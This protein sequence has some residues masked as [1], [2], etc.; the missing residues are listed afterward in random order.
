SQ[1]GASGPAVARV[2]V[3]LDFHCQPRM[4]ARTA[5]LSTIISIP[6]RKASRQQRSLKPCS[7]AFD[8]LSRLSGGGS[9]MDHGHQRAGHAG[10]VGMLNDVAAIDDSG[11]P[12]LNEFFGGVQTIIVRCV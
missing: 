5:M 1:R 9:L 11:G 2:L 7:L 6:P 8:Q 3:W 12:L 4:G 10:G